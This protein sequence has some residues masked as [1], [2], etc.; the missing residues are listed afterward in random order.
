MFEYALHDHPILWHSWE[1]PDTV[2]CFGPDGV[3][4][5]SREAF[6]KELLD[7]DTMWVQH[8]AFVYTQHAATMN[9]VPDEAFSCRCQSC[10]LAEA[11]ILR[12]CD[13]VWTA[14]LLFSPHQGAVTDRLHPCVWSSADTCVI[15]WRPSRLMPWCGPGLSSL[16]LLTG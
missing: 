16:S 2:F 6:K 15:L 13:A 12:C 4:E 10:S 5:G 11:C 8:C 14:H 9:A 1:L 3:K 7:H